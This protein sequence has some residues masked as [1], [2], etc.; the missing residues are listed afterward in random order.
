MSLL[1][2]GQVVVTEGGRDSLISRGIAEFQGS[3]ATHA[4]I[5]VGKGRAVEA[6]FP[7][8]RYLNVADRVRELKAQDRAFAILDLPD[9]RL[10]RRLLTA[11]KAEEFVGRFYDVGQVL[12]YALTNRFWNDGTGTLVCSRVVTGAFFGGGKEN[13]FDGATLDR[14]YPVGHPRRTNLAS[15]YATPAD[16]LASRLQLVEFF[17][18]SRV[19]TLDALRGAS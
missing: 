1:R 14:H 9:L 17:P 8:V 5:G 11:R 16:L 12:L 2:L 4:F 10:D 7:R 18:S 13:L 3:W 6:H 19:H 15:G